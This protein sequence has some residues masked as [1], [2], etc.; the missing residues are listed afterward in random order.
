M[1]STGGNK[2]LLPHETDVFWEAAHT[3]LETTQW[4]EV[5]GAIKQVFLEKRYEV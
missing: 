5:Q 4:Q 3:N 1:K 2:F